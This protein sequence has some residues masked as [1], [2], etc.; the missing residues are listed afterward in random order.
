MQTFKEFLRE[1]TN[2]E[3]DFREVMIIYEK[4][5]GEN[6][7][8]KFKPDE[9]FDEDRKEFVEEFYKAWP[10]LN[11]ICYYE[12]DR[13]EIQ[14]K[15]GMSYDE[16]M[17]KEMIRLFSPSSDP[18]H[19]FLVD[20]IK[21]LYFDTITRPDSKDNGLDIET[22]EKKFP[23]LAK[24][25]TKF[26]KECYTAYYSKDRSKLDLCVKIKK[27]FE[28]AFW[29]NISIINPFEDLAWSSANI[30][31]PIEKEDGFYFTIEKINPLEEYEKHMF[32]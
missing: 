14:K 15:P 3:M 16:Q 32:T 27:Y 1:N 7:E 9:K 23:R 10:I 25:L 21:A 31:N 26:W 6:L 8:G 13:E 18:V 30:F 11:D 20:T 5:V 12:L 28:D 29:I 19:T 4:G 22:Y 24:L 17:K 2:E